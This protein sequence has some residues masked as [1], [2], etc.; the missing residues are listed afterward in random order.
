[1]SV[2]FRQRT[3]GE[4]VQILWRRKW[5]IVL[6]AI[7]IA[8][9]I[10][11]VVLRLPNVYE[12]ST[13]LIVKPPTISSAFVPTLSDVDLTMR[14]NNISQIAASRSSLEPLI[15]RYDL[16]REERQ[17]GVPMESIVER[18][19]A[20][21][22]V[23]IDT[24]R[25][26]TNAFR[27]SYRARDPRQTQVVTRELASK[28][29]NG[30]TTSLAVETQQ[31]KEFFEKQLAEVKAQLD[32]VDQRRIQYMIQNRDNLP[33]QGQSL[34]GRLSGLRSQQAAL[35]TD[36]GRMRDQ[37]AAMTGQMNDIMQQMQRDQEDYIE[38]GSDPR[39]SPAYGQLAQRKAQLEAELEEMLLT[40]KP[41]N[42]D[43]KKVQAQIDATKRAMDEMVSQSDAR[44]A[45]IKER[46]AKRPDLRINNL[47][48][49]LEFF[50][51]EFARQQKA[52]DATSSEIAEIESRVNN[53]PG[54]EIGLVSLNREYETK[55][56]Y[57]DDLLRKKQQIDL[58]GAAN[59]EA[60]T[61]TIQVVDPANLPQQPIAPQRPRLL[62]TGILL[63]LGV[64]LAFAAA[65]EVPRLLTI[66]TKDDAEHYTG[67]PVLISVPELM[68][69]QE[70][71]SIPRRRMLLVAAGIV[72]TIVSIPVLTYA[73]KFTNVL[74]RF[75]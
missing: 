68:T 56:A 57:Y 11:L 19:R 67:L 66:Q 62:L 8:T 24:S 73:L 27:I 25:N 53:V 50:D 4:Y 71:R 14:I 38:M 36:I 7:A 28:Y 74:T 47:K 17:Q 52:L 30:Q 58:A 26:V 61:E 21:M 34:I 10:T 32:E 33:S 64:G 63:G 22:S 55:K 5:L 54:A 59:T 39:Q 49:Q 75:V 44:L 60:K 41:Q 9:A 13:L 3:P 35:I 40:L 42:P 69:P 43:V 48:R 2:E 23:H 18:M 31:G 70:A 65:F 46:L 72:I 37:R 45:A 20:D 6:P 12:S 16:Y 51:S 29:V 15:L 1:M